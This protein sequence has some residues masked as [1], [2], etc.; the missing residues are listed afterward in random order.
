M[1][2][3]SDTRPLQIEVTN[4]HLG[5]LAYESRFYAPFVHSR[6]G[7]PLYYSYEVRLRAWGPKLRPGQTTCR[8]QADISAQC[9][10]HMLSR[11]APG[12]LIGALT[13]VAG[14]HV[15]MLGSYAPYGRHS[16][17]YA[18]LQADLATVDRGRTP[19]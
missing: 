2:G 17:Q 9:Q 6:S 14:A 19:W 3:S 7:T 15:V 1:P 16:K 11:K 18:W 13:Q 4:G 10:L 8:G 12:L 5:F